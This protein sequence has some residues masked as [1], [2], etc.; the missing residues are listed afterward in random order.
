MR[1]IS[2]TIHGFKRFAEPTTLRVDGDLTAL[3]G[4]N[5]VGKT[6]VLAAL[7]HTNDA[8]PFTASEL[9]RGIDSGQLSYPV[10]LKFLL[11][12]PDIDA[13]APV[14]GAV[15]VRWYTFS[16]AT[17]GSTE[18]VLEPP[19]HRDT[20]S[21][22][23]LAK[24]LRRAASHRTL[25]ALLDEPDSEFDR[26]AM[27]AL[28]DALDAGVEEDL[29]AELLDSLQAWGEQLSGEVPD[30]A[31]LYIR[32]LPQA[33]ADHVAREREDRPTIA[34]GRILG[35]RRPR[36][37][38]FG[39]DERSLDNTYELPQLE[40]PSGALQNLASLAGLDL[41]ELA[42]TLRQ[43]RHG[44]VQGLRDRANRTLSEF[45]AENWKQTGLTVE[46]NLSGTDLELY[47]REDSGEYWQ[48]AERSDGL[49]WFVALVAYLHSEGLDTAPI[50]LVDEAEQ[51][52]HYDGQADLVRAFERQE[53]V[54]DV[55][56]T[57]H[58][59]GCLPQDLGTGVRVVARRGESASEIRNSLWSDEDL[60]DGAGF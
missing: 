44:E 33:L 52:L 50:L 15:G 36:F 38:L 9:T 12:P 26:A 59:A 18:F 46:L 16:K 32:S 34:A 22:V 37:L 30:A 40:S 45:F 42:A 7:V 28:A 6:S 48:L 4:P 55:I 23:L 57:T 51:H 17:D 14:A 29:P 25:Q 60:R 2:A 56:Y 43:E 39:D 1:L 21:R 31:P 3:V 58:S 24:D 47:V 5:E 27:L 54:A 41:A 20:S 8:Q 53:A 49:R 13:L 19:V 10:R 35:E 11:E